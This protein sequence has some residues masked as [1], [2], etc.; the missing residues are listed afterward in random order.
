M[1]MGGTTAILSG[2]GAA[3]GNAIEAARRNTSGRL[4]TVA[5]MPKRTLGQINSGKA[6]RPRSA[7]KGKGGG[8]GGG[9]KAP[10]PSMGGMAM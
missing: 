4:P 3:P 10:K 6:Q 5:P 1:N 7:K 9:A 8:G 2:Y